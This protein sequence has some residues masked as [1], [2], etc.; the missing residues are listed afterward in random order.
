MKNPYSAS[1]GRFTDGSQ[2]FRAKPASDPS[3]FSFKGD[4]LLSKKS[5]TVIDDGLFSFCGA[6]MRPQN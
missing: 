5:F 3:S 6:L 4:W 2:I 1:P